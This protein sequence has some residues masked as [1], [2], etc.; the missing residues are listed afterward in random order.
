M[1][2][3]GLNILVT[4]ASGF[5]AEHLIPR[6]KALGCYV[7]GTDRKKIPSAIVDKF[8][9]SNLLNFEDNFNKLNA[10]KID[11]VIHLAAARAD[12]GVSDQEFFT[13]NFEATKSLLSFCKSRG[14]NQFLFISS[15]SVMPQESY[16]V[17]S[18]QSPNQP[19]N[20]YGKSKEAAENLLISH[21]KVSPHFCLNIIRPT[22]L[23][24]PS[25]PD[26][27]GIYRA[28]DNNI[29]RLIDAISRNRFAFI[30]NGKTPKTTAYIE[31]FV[32]AI[33]FVPRSKAGFQIFIYCDEPPMSTE[34]LVRTIR[35]CIGKRGLGL[36]L[37]LVLVTP[38]ASI[39]DVLGQ[40]FK[41]NFPITRARIE[42]FNRPTNFTR[43]AL[44]NLRFKQRL[45][46]RDALKMTVDWYIKLS[47]ENNISTF[48]FRKK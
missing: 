26:K 5:T 7:I 1:H 25:D 11:Y 33:L 32:D 23:Y 16:S 20:A 47:N 13:D 30:G 31:N 3:S 45:S 8:I 24:G 44:N 43:A 39:F 40:I 18:E 28:M 34:D 36:K 27:T 42:T 17:I 10:P 4:G 29:F 41:I 37:P 46:T 9:S 22:V 35:G 19:I 15:I 6:L 21:A 14:I 48:F 12:W 2:L 38:L